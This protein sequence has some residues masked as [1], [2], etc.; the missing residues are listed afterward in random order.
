MA[1]RKTLDKL[2]S[3]FRGRTLKTVKLLAKTGLGA[4]K[5]SLGNREPGDEADEDASVAAAERLL[6]ELDG[7]KGLAMKFG[8]MASYLDHSLPPKAQRVLARLQSES[9]PM[10]YEAMVEVVEQDL[11]QAPDVLFDEFER[12]P[13]AAA[14]IGQ[15]HRARFD[16]RA[17]AVKI[18]YPGVQEALRS[19]LSTVGGIA[20]LGLALSALDG[21]G[22]AGELSARVMEECDYEREARNQTLFN[23]LFADDPVRHVPAVVFERS[24]SRVLTS[25]MDPGRPFRTFVDDASPDEIDRAGE[26]IFETCFHSI[27]HH[28]VF[29]ADP[30]P[31]NYLF[32]D[33]SVTF[34]DFGCLKWFSPQFID[35]WKGLAKSVLDEDRAAFPDRFT[36]TGMVARP[37]NFDWDAMWSAMSHLYAPF[38]SDEATVYTGEFIQSANDLMGFKNPNKL[39]MTMPPDWLFVNRLQFGLLSVLAQ[40]GARGHWGRY[41]RRAVESKTA[42]LSA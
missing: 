29:N 38:R 16:G 37:R 24:G 13:F 17:V 27:F 41:F 4:A 40:M 14:S 10:T 36:A 32:G 33:E 3:G 26:I 9:Q 8:Q 12:E 1:Q 34:L 15:V 20:K 23:E 30:H 6:K 31:G 39:R 22:L 19:D 5:R 42:P 35:T 28:C 18:Q 7:L 2:A 25:V 21:G 11:G